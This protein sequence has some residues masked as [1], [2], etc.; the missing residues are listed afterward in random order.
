MVHDPVCE[1]SI[2]YMTKFMIPET[3]NIF[4]PYVKNEYN[5]EGLEKSLVAP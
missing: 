1:E 3:P 2:E 5:M 4:P